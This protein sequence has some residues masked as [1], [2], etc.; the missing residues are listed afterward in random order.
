[1]REK[2]QLGTVVAQVPLKLNGQDS[3]VGHF[4]V[5]EGSRILIVIDDTLFGTETVGLTLGV[6]DNGVLEMG[7][8]IVY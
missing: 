1:M 7:S 4:P 2:R 6:L 5:P 8:H 3:A